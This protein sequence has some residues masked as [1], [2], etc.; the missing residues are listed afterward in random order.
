MAN[1]QTLILNVKAVADMKDVITNVEGIKTALSKLK[2]PDN[3]KT[4]FSNQFKDLE[5]EI[6]RYQKLQAN[7]FKTKGDVNAFTKSGN[8]IIHI[9][10]TIAKK[11]QSIDDSTLRESFKDLGVQ[12]V[13]R[14]KTELESLQSTLK[15][16]IGENNFAGD[17]KNSL[18]DVQK[19]LKDTNKDASELAK[20]LSTSTFSTFTKNLESGRLDLAAKNLKSIEDQINALKNPP[21]KLI[22]W[23]ETLKNKFKDLSG[24]SDIQNIATRLEEIKGK[25]T[26]AEAEALQQIINQFREYSNA[27]NKSAEDTRK[28]TED[29]KE[30]AESTQQLTEE[31]GQVKSR[32]QHFLGLSNAVNLFKRAVRSAFETVK[33]L[34]AA[35]TETAVVT[36]K[37]VSDMWAKLPEYTKRANQ[38]GISTVEAYRAATLYYQQGLNDEQVEG[39]SIETLKMA[40]IAGLDAAE[41]TDR[42]TNALRG[43][44]MEINQ[45]NAQ[46]VADVYSQLAAMSASNVDEISTAMTKV[47][48]LAHNANMDFE[49]T[50]A[51][52]AQIIETTRESAETAGTALKTVVAR[53]SEVKKLYDENQLKGTD[54]EGQAIDVNKVATALRT[55]GIDLNK[56]FLGEVG[57]DDIFMELASKWDTLTSV[58][59]RY[60][61]TQAAGSRQQSRFIALMQDYARTQELVGAAYEANGASAK[62]FEKTQESLQNKLARLKN[63]WDEFLMGITNN[64]VIKEIVKVLTDILNFINKLTEAFGETASGI[65]KLGVAGMTLLSLKKAFQDGGL[66]S[67]LLGKVGIDVGVT[68]STKVAGKSFIADVA[69][70]GKTWLAAVRQSATET[71][72]K[73]T[74]NAAAGGI[75]TL[76]WAGIAL[77]IAY[78]GAK[79]QDYFTSGNKEVNAT[80]KQIDQQQEI[81]DKNENLLKIQQDTLD[82][83]NKNQKILKTSN[84]RQERENARKEIE[85]T[86]TT[87]LVTN[88][89]F[90]TT[91]NAG[92]KILNKTALTKSIENLTKENL[93]EQNKLNFLQAKL[94][95]QRANNIN[96]SFIEQSPNIS[97][98]DWGDRILGSLLFTGYYGFG[99][100]SAIGFYKDL[101]EIATGSDY[102]GLS[103]KD[104]F[105]LKH[106]KNEQQIKEYQTQAEGTLYQGASTILGEKISDQDII[107]TV[108]K[109]YA[110]A[111]STQDVGERTKD[112]SQVSNEL[113]D[114]ARLAISE[115]GK[116]VLDIISGSYEGPLNEGDL[117]SYYD[118][119]TS[120]QQNAIKTLLGKSN[121][122]IQGALIEYES[123]LIKSFK[124][125]S[126]G[127]KEDIYKTA[128]DSGLIITTND[129]NNINQLNLEQLS[130]FSDIMSE[131][132]GIVDTATLQE[133]FQS[134]PDL[135]FDEL[136]Q[137][138]GFFQNFNLDNPIQAFQQ[139]EKAISSVDND[140]VFGKLL[141]NIK[142]TNAELFTT[143]S[144]VQSFIADG[145]DSLASSIDDFIKENGKITSKNIEDLA[146]NCDEL[147]FLL[148]Q[149]TISAQGLASAFTLFENGSIAIDNI[150]NSL[151]AALS[152]GENF[153][154]LIGNVSSWIEDFNEG[155]DLT[156]GTQHI[157]DLLGKAEEY[158]SNWQFG[159]KPLKNIYDHIFGPDA[160]DTYMRNGGWDKP[161][162]EIEKDLK[163]EIDR[164]KGLAENEGLGALQFLAGQ[165]GSGITEKGKN[166][167]SWDLDYEHASDAISDIA[168]KL[169]VT[170][171]VAR[172]IIESWASH[173]WDLGEA[174]DNLNF[175]D[176][177][178]AF[179]EAL[180][181]E[182]VITE[183]E[184]NALIQITG[185]TK[186]EIL[187]AIAEI[188]GAGH[189]P[190]VVSWQDENGNALTGDKLIDE[191]NKK[192][193]KSFVTA[194]GVDYTGVLKGLLEGPNNE[195]INLDK[196]MSRLINDFK[197][198]P[199]QAST[200]ADNIAS[201]VDKNFSREIKVP[202]VTVLKDDDGNP[203][204]DDKGNVKIEAT[205][206]TKIVYGDSVA[207]L[208]A[209]EAAAQAAAAQSNMAELLAG[210]PTDRLTTTVADALTAA[211]EEGAA[212]IKA[213]I[214]GLDLVV[215]IGFTGVFGGLFG[216]GA[217]AGAKG[218]IVGSYAGG[219][220]N[221]RVKPGLALTGE[222]DP[223]I[224][225]NADKGYAYLAGKHGPEIN[226][227]RPGDQVFNAQDTRAILRRSGISSFAKGTIHSYK[228]SKKE[229]KGGYKDVIAGDNG[230]TNTNS[231]S[232]KSNKWENTL[233]WLYN[234]MEDIAELE[235]IQNQISEKH[236]RY[237]EDISKTGR[238]LYNLTQQE[239]NNLYTQRD[240]YQEAFTRRMQEMREQLEANSKYSQ[241]VWWNDKDKTIEIDWDAINKIKDKDKYDEVTDLISKLEKIQDQMDEAEEAL[242]DI[243][244]QIIELEKRYLDEFIDLQKRVYDALVDSYQK[245][246]D[247]L[248]DL[249]DTLN[250]S[251]EKI[252]NSIQKEIDLQRQIRENTETEKN[253]KELEARLAYLRR[254][255]TGANEKEIR[256]LEKQ[257]EDARNDYLDKLV[258]QALERLQ[259]SNDDAAEQRERQIDLLTEQ[260]DYWKEVGALW[261]EVAKLLDEGINGDGSLIRGSTL[262]QILQEAD[263]W[264]A[265]SEQQREVWA[266]ELILAVNQAGAYLLKI[267]EGFNSLSE[268]IWAIIPESSIPAKH[269]ATG[270]LAT[271]TGPAWLDG[272]ASEPEYVLNARQT[273]AFLRLAEVLPAMFSAGGSGVTNNLGG[274]LYVELNMNVGEIGSDYDV[275]RL[276]DRIKRDLYDAGSYRNVNAVNFLR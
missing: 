114:L 5:K 79:V 198:S 101:F 117:Q 141:G 273:D 82:D 89:D 150:T 56:Y 213:A 172:A 245:Q 3:L 177:I 260:L 59:Q 233:D 162:D 209:A 20:K 202:V 166:Q 148:D 255:T 69:T 16:K 138:Q 9:Y 270:G 180:G 249:N 129:I 269:Y 236:E 253:I 140:S 204:T 66:I 18:K 144:F 107:L 36:D 182:T 149:D 186:E 92:N 65:L 54:E 74:K 193:V 108:S 241:Y 220:S 157:V 194:S 159:N 222:E 190:V 67:K 163:G 139:L 26:G 196:L 225:W 57:L 147:K 23:L 40:R 223:E 95:Q 146:E 11:I 176:T 93:E 217:G 232:E 30:N 152:A 210:V 168:T 133:L 171:E 257:L 110:K 71:G 42:M 266:N 90:V 268:G 160:Y 247:N 116:K 230:N 267:A 246:I 1:S 165:E 100:S 94:D 75:S 51:F 135:S 50:A 115:N 87:L 137:I 106:T 200:I 265:M 228:Q 121:D 262:E 91:D 49:T 214:E 29:Q 199:S 44:N 6:E 84:N 62:Q 274:N 112:I 250:D 195:F 8:N 14:L 212:A 126:K 19:Q 244:G 183:Q 239:L 263:G 131:A 128:L 21:E 98:Q 206:E 122:E 105:D 252:L 28:L 226:N 251:N 237:L 208:D 153:E 201:S 78:I 161:F 167:F 102:Q 276:V 185:K 264:K 124:E 215:K 156:E 154:T 179:A 83:Y 32:I 111:I 2:L 174:W 33:E 151:L 191:F 187:A 125:I 53:F 142:E 55:A 242:W 248:E 130:Q 103:L 218:G 7:G 261:P 70:A 178:G 175:K 13:Q 127:R 64:V 221:N 271:S 96:K 25:L 143:S 73:T 22:G 192:F 134:F 275:D 45:V 76:G 88:P 164:V 80:Q 104:R 120:S 234:L 238:D 211:A 216:G 123:N 46:R 86:L 188:K 170:D 256:D 34:D 203:I 38:L 60:I 254:D 181:E 43:F 189:V 47:A 72:I 35:M 63:A 31:L 119:L 109:A 240:N 136:S 243:E 118:K 158:I 27:V 145:Y 229:A 15:A 39:L 10:E 77:L 24:N 207:A 235:R 17:L 61:A 219:S 12:E 97:R 227:L 272:T 197:L 184:L 37:T 169:N 113:S 4:S 68:K 85:T 155:T 132:S 99:D 259:Q 205:T 58:Q 258:D 48:S 81:I 52:L 224:V 41:A 173:M 231:K